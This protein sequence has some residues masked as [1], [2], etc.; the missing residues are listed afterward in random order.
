MSLAS[1]TPIFSENSLSVRTSHTIMV[2]H[3]LSV[4][5]CLISSIFFSF[6][7]HPILFDLTNP[8]SICFSDL[9][10][11]LFFDF[12]HFPHLFKNPHPEP[13]FGE[14]LENF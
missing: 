9:S 13:P 7:S 1:G 11:L 6:F 3:D 5:F 4:R 10:Y 2:S 14:L 12:A 8:L